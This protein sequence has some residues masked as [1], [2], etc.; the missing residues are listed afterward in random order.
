MKR[1]ASLLPIL[2]CLSMSAC[3]QSGEPGADPVGAGSSS[4]TDTDTD[5]TASTPTSS[6]ETGAVTTGP[7]STS[8]STTTSG[9]PD[10]SSTAMDESSG[11]E[12]SSSD[13]SGGSLEDCGNGMQDPGETCDEGYINN[14]NDGACTMACQTAKCG[15]GLVWAGHETCDH[16]DDNNNTTYNGCTDACELGPHCGDGVIQVE[17]EECDAGENNGNGESSPDGVPCEPECKFYAKVVF[18]TS[19][20]YTGKEV[21]GVTGAHLLCRER[22][23]AAGLDNHVNFKAFISAAGFIPADAEQFSHADIPY[24]RV[25]GIR[26]ADNW[27]DL[28]QE[29]P[30]HGIL[31]AENGK[32]YAEWYVWTGTDSEGKMYIPEQTCAGW[33]SDS[34]LAK[35]RMGRTSVAADKVKWTSD[36]NGECDFSA[37]L[38]CFE[39]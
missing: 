22:A 23:E 7:G 15:D 38:Y 25:D 31:I 37:K 10:S 13:A 35:G 9:A 3:P 21:D 33:G 8:T 11:G 19:T 30:A 14:K 26:I 4:G 17:E 29:G 2:G 20:T 39:Q 5:P 1:S 27:E 12:I 24:V 34:P 32:S 16:G 6:G 18:V 36:T 28:V